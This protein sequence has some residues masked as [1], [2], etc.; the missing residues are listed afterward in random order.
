MHFRELLY[1]SNLSPV[2]SVYKT[3]LI[4]EHENHTLTLTKKIKLQFCHLISHET[5]GKTMHIL[6]I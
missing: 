6:L 1:A 4:S 2:E 3:I 5:A